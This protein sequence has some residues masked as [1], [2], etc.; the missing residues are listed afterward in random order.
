MASPCAKFAKK[1]ATCVTASRCRTCTR[2]L[3]AVQCLCLGMAERRRAMSKVG[4]TASK[5]MV[6]PVVDFWKVWRSAGGGLGRLVV[7][8]LVFLLLFGGVGWDF[9]FLGMAEGARIR[10]GD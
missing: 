8:V 10:D 2:A 5:W 9:G 3:S 7:W 6:K 4:A 1:A